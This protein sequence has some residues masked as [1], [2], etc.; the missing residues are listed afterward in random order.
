MTPLQQ[1]TFEFIMAKGEI[2][3]NKQIPHFATKISIPFND[4]TS[5]Y[6]DF[7][8]LCPNVF[9]V[10][11]C[12]FIVCGKDLKI[13]DPVNYFY[14]IFSLLSSR[15]SQ[16]VCLYRVVLIDPSWTMWPCSS[17][18]RTETTG[19]TQVINRSQ[20]A[21]TRS[22]IISSRTRSENSAKAWTIVPSCTG[23]SLWGKCSLCWMRRSLRGKVLVH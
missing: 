23:H 21:W 4:H 13:T 18:S 9:K 6:W 11:C 8:C 10:L 17:T 5:N 14:S 20:G 22:T 1:A 7:P 15:T 3:H 2:A 19:L 16:A 12:R